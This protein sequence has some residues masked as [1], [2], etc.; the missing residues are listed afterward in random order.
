[1]EIILTSDIAAFPIFP[2]FPSSVDA[3]FSCD[4]CLL[5]LDWRAEDFSKIYFKSE[6]K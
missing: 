6:I 2:F 1:M 4:S 5:T 3:S